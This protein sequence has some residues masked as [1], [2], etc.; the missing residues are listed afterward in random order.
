MPRP[1]VAFRGTAELPADPAWVFIAIGNFDGQGADDVLLRHDDGRWR[2]HPMAG[3]R[4]GGEP[5]EIPGLPKD[6]R[7]RWAGAGDFNGDGTDDI[8][9]RR[10]DGIWVYYAMD[11]FGVVADESGRARVVRDLDYRP[12]AIGDFDG[13]GKDDVLV[14]RK[15]G[16]WHYY[17]MD[18]R[19]NAGRRAR[20]GLPSEWGWRLAGVGDFDGDGTDDVFV[21]HFADGRW[22]FHAG[23]GR[24]SA[25]ARMTSSPDFHVAA[26]G[27]FNG[28]GQDDFLVRRSTTG[29]W[30]YYA[31]H[32][33]NVEYRDWVN[34]T[35]ELV[36]TVTGGVP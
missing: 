8:L 20:A 26:A 14:R 7:F 27:D 13:D 18:G 12:S 11:G 15:D 35:R 28:D 33:A 23:A 31:L 6:V 30:F 24:A 1:G 22:R 36:W 16:G 34:L 10:D 29:H 5:V 19:G 21:R 4:A 3:R 2:I 25:A 32:G 17:R 9:L